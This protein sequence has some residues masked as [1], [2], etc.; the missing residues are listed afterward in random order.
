MADPAPEPT[1]IMDP[2]LGYRRLDPLPGRAELDGFYQSA[3]VDLVR[4]GRRFPELGRLLGADD[5]AAREREWLKRTLH[6]DV[7][8]AL[9]RHVPTPSGRSLLDVGCGIGEFI[10]TA[11]ERGW[12]AYGLEPSIEA[13]EFARSRGRPVV[14]AT[15]ED[16]LAQGGP[17]APPDAV[18]LT[19]VLEHLTEP[20]ALLRR[21]RE[22]VRPGGA[23]VVRVPNDFNPLQLMARDALGHA[24]WW[25]A[26]PDHV[27]YFTHESLRRV[28]EANGFEV[29]DQWA[30][31]PM[32][33]F[34]LMGD[35]YV[36][37]P[38]AGP[39][40]HARRRRLELSL[41]PEARREFG[42]AL[43]GL[44]WGRNS[45]LVARSTSAT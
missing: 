30:D 24:A 42:R 14:C 31:F 5:D 7:L 35:D 45:V 41:E 15:I 32:E 29:V 34:L 36:A 27:N 19:N 11:R 8:D 23:L 21:A 43:V 25:I 22:I 26:A 9:E 44:G 38:A 39:L 12:D 13:A 6:L 1:V 33:L 2:D 17:P 40:A 16:Y 28:V 4:Q 18:V 10:D 3:Y 37:D 20:I